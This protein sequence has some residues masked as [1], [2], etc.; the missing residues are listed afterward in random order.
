MAKDGKIVRT[1]LP[2]TNLQILHNMKHF[3]Q[4]KPLS[5]R[6]HESSSLY[7]NYFF[8]KC[9]IDRYFE[10]E[11][12]RSRGRGQVCGYTRVATG[13]PI[14]LS[15]LSFGY[16]LGFWSTYRGPFDHFSTA[17]EICYMIAT[18]ILKIDSKIAEIIEV[19]VGTC[20]TKIIFFDSV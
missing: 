10:Q 1:H 19:K 15:P 16:F 7:G 20:S 13:C 11:Y 8:S 17:L 5:Y 18:K 9:D 14:S 6:A 3:R 12:V 4:L 2:L